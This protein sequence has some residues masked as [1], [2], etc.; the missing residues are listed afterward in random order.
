MTGMNKTDFLDE[1]MWI[2]QDADPAELLASRHDISDV[3]HDVL[4]DALKDLT[5]VELLQLAASALPA[6]V[7]MQADPAHDMRWTIEG[8]LSLAL[9]DEMVALL[10]GLR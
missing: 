3:A 7:R 10:Q 4:D 1:V 5:D 9:N 2:L 6:V 8:Q